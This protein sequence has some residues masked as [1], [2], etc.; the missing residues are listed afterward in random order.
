M[1]KIKFE[2]TSYDGSKISQE[3]LNE[4]Y[5][6]DGILSKAISR[7]LIRKEPEI[8][9][10]INQDKKKD[11]L[12]HEIISNVHNILLLSPK[13]LKEWTERIDKDF[14]DVFST[15]NKKKQTV[16][17]GLG[18]IILNAFNYNTYRQSILVE[19]AKKLNVKCCPY[20]NMQY[21]L[22]A[23]EQKNII[24]RLVKF[25]FDHFY[26]KCK[27]PMLSMSLYNLI[28]SCSICNNS[29]LDNN[30]SLSYHPYHSDICKQFKFELAIDKPADIFCGQKIKDLINVNFIAEDSKKQSELDDFV[31]TFHL[32][33]LYQRHGD[34]A[35]EAFDK[36]YELPYYSNIKNFN[37][38]S[39]IEPEYIKRLWLGT[40][41]D[42][43]DIE[44]R[45]LTKFKQDLRE[46]AKRIKCNE[47]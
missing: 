23:E 19:L 1:N 30:L 9:K 20:C 8:Q 15:I 26:S 27:Y 11:N 13:E 22:Y 47:K 41:L 32:K 44:K 33:A 31:Q 5:D 24:Q 3:Q 42:E 4:W 2:R 39:S 28:P 7:K 14:H 37:C 18:K 43:K 46:Q 45:P 35:Q 16:A 38:I 25:Q 40:Y 17:T 29:K 36:A 34:I 6:K 10:E 21:T 12:L